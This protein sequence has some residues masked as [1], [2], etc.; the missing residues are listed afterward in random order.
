MKKQHLALAVAVLALTACSDA[1]IAA[2]SRI[3]EP[4]IIKCYS[5]NEIILEDES[6]G[7][8]EQSSRGS[9]LFYKSKKTGKYVKAYAD[10]LVIC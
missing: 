4:S 9:G 6:T 3:N 8:I 5:G 2:F 7:M 10:C 1:D